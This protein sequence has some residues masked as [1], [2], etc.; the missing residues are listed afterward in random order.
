MRWKML[1]AA[2]AFLLCAGLAV[3]YL[4]TASFHEL[5]RS[6]LIS[7]IEKA[8]GMNCRIDRLSLNLF[9]GRFE[10]RGL[11]LVPRARM[12]GSIT[13]QAEEIRASLS[14]SSFWRFRVRLDELSVLRP[15][16]ELISSGSRSSWNPEGMLKTLKASFR[17][18]AA[19]VAVQEGR[20]HLD[21]RT[22]PLN[23]SLEDLDCQIRYAEKRPSYKIHLA[24]R[25]SRVFYKRRDIVHGL[26]TR[27]DLSVQGI[28]I[29]S[30]E[31]RHGTSLLRGHGSIGD[32]AS[33]AILLYANGV[34]SAK[35]FTLAH[36][37]LSEGRGDVNVQADF[38]R[39]KDGIRSKGT[40]SA[41]GGGY[42]RMNY[43]DLAGAYE[44]ARDVLHLRN[45]TGR[46]AR[47]SFRING[48]I[49]LR[50]TREAPNR[51]NVTT[52]K[53]PLVEAGRLLNLPLENFENTAD[54]TAALLWHPGRRDFRADCSV[55]LHGLTD[56]EAARAKG[57]LLGG[58]IQFTAYEGGAV[59][60]SSAS[61][62]S[63]STSLQTSGGEEAVFRVRLATTRPAEPLDLLSGFSPRVA[64]LCARQPDL[65]NMAGS[66]EVEGDVRV[67]S[68]SDI[69][70]EG[71][72]AVRD[73][74]LRSYRVDDL[75]ARV[76]F[77]SPRLDVR[78]L[79]VRRG[80]Q[81]VAGELDLG[82]A[83]MER[84]SSLR[85][86]GTLHGISLADLK[87][88]GVESPQVA[89]ILDASGSVWYSDG[90]WEGDG[91]IIAEKGSFKG[92]RFD[93]LRIRA[94]IADQQLRLTRAEA[95]RGV[96]RF[97]AQGVVDLKTRQLNLT[98]TLDG[99][100]LDQIPAVQ[101]RALPVQGRVRATGV[102]KGTPDNPSFSGAFDLES[103]HYGSWNLG[104]GKGRVE[105][106]QGMVRGN[107]A[108]Q[109]KFG[110]LTAQG[111]I[112]TIS[113]YPG[114]AVLEFKDLDVQ[115]IFT[116]RTP[117][118]LEGLSTALQGKIDVDGE[119]QDPARLKI[120]GE[121]DGARF[122]VLDYELH[123]EG[124]IE[125]TVLNR[126]F[127]A[128]R[129]HFVGE[130]TSLALSG[131]VPLDDSA[132]LDLNLSGSLNLRLLEGLEG[133]L[134][135][136]GTAAL[137]I[138]ASGAKKNPQFI[139]RVTLRDAAFEHAELPFRMSGMQG[140]IVFSRNLIRLES[141][142]G[143]AASGTVQLSGVLEHQNAVLRSVNMG[144]S[145]RNA[146]VLY[147]EGFRSV[148]NAELLLSGNRELQILSG[149]IDVLRSEY[150]RSFNLLGQFGG[151]GVA[152]P[153]T[154]T[155]NPALMGLRLNVEI[156]S[157]NG[158]VID[159]EL[160]KVRGNLGLT[161]GG[162][163]AY[164]Y[165][166]GRAEVVEG[167]IFFRGSRFE[168][169]HAT[170]DF[171]DRT[172]INPVLEI[173]AEADVK[174]YRLILDAVGTMDHLNLNVSSDPPMSTVE[175][176]SL[177][178]TGTTGAETE[179]SRG[180]TQAVGMT[181]AS[182]LSENLTGVIGKRVQRVFGLESFRVDPFLAGVE[183]DP[184]ARVTISERL[185]KD[186]VITYSRNLSTSQEQIV[187]IE[188]DISR[189][190]SV[191]ATRDEDGKYGLD[192]RFRKRLR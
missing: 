161:L 148:V 36:P 122:K 50:E 162:T 135:T 89:G 31:F 100:S 121:V 87:D 147:P 177:L 10:I 176:L 163:S 74:Q 20:F 14:L 40:F 120:R 108:I 141:V 146:R 12:A 145:I 73:G 96:A 79:S 33:P 30:Y 45:V 191:V 46:I 17:L 55:T 23:L 114:K 81:S 125:F 75:S 115:R 139:G 16:L 105:F 18:E 94:Q 133:N 113:G 67:K 99:F 166:T 157:D 57:T 61:L 21:S 187:V 82:L 8:T 13:L 143:T 160:A 136:G 168:I 47:G 127:R 124:S 7:R 190:L 62:S 101:E 174:S 171:V 69:E 156:R 142:R 179:T 59:H 95:T 84:I 86:Q 170:A 53:V 32:W 85:F 107:A 153:G 129:I 132:R 58:N 4:N 117:S 164:P 140:D 11:E 152:Q 159:N 76:L 93:R 167:T 106:S 68:A 97:S 112:S 128:Q 70:F 39:D 186:L 77:S 169:L 64:D 15:Y 25:Q 183:S 172:R 180:E 6:R 22:I 137:N 72:V 154:F 37:S 29:E 78:S 63:P 35:D 34:V 109:S 26:D 144:I 149:D 110:S 118:Y 151:R 65:R 49:Q 103:L 184:T 134:R 155:T 188:Y 185:S 102:L 90:I 178:T 126:N 48:D 192:F 173:R 2:F 44:I 38:R 54:A 138:R 131:T 83:G 88:L 43:R 189:N 60:I 28:E 5:V 24:Y 111:S 1:I 80:T 66:Y 91:E 27:L 42:R 51:V 9:R 98:T 182:V 56:A 116:G 130:G 19:K 123:N 119:F 181:A 104:R 52:S 3:W 175:I 158:L 41:P 71:K 165:L 150:V 92:E